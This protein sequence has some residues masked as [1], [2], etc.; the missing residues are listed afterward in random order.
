MIVPCKI[1][2]LHLILAKSA[3]IVLS[4]LQTAQ[5]TLKTSK[6]ASMVSPSLFMYF[7]GDHEHSI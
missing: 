4:S 7:E 3:V 5:H 1:F 2:E 6:S